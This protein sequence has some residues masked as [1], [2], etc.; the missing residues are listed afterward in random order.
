MKISHQLCIEQLKQFKVNSKYFL[1]LK[2]LHMVKNL[3]P[4]SS[5]FKIKFMFKHI[6]YAVLLFISA[7]TI[8]CTK[9]STNPDD[10]NA[11]PPETQT[12]AGTFACKIN[13][14]VWRYKDPNYEFLSTKPKTRWEFD[15]TCQNG[16]LYIG[17][18]QYLNGINEDN[19]LVIS[20]DSLLTYK[21]RGANNIGKFHFGMEY[22]LYSSNNSTC[23]D[24]STT[25]LIDTSS[26]FFSSGKLII[27]KLD[28]TAKII[29]GTFYST[30]K[31]SG[32]DTLKITEGRFDLKYQ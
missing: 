31:Q 19:L 4:I 23:T 32:C 27:S 1:T 30:I 2:F 7:T 15:P 14:V 26:N 25:R 13:G 20:A 5:F 12:G 21:E 22:T 3:F 24:F 11:L 8:Q 10:L 9:T 28:Q 6:F 29:S 17:G 16:N 18:V